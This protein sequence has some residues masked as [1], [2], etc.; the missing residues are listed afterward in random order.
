M[1]L[2][3]RGFVFSFHEFT[4]PCV[5]LF[6]IGPDDGSLLGFE[7]LTNMVS[8]MDTPKLISKILFLL[9]LPA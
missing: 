5:V 4:K 7:T 3:I 8:T 1:L 6:L 2:P 9:L